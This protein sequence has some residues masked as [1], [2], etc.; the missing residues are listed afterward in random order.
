MSIAS[1]ADHEPTPTSSPR[2]GGSTPRTL[3]ALGALA[4]SSALASCGVDEVELGHARESLTMSQCSYFADGGR[5]RICHLTGSPRRP[6]NSLRLGLAGCNDHS[7][8]AGDYIAV[9]DPTCNGQGC[10][11]EGAPW[12]DTVECCQGLS[13]LAGTCR[14]VCGD[15]MVG[16]TEQ[17][18]DGNSIDTDA[19]TSAC[20]P[21][22]C[23]DGL[24]GP[25]EQC[26][27][28]N[29]IDTDACTSACEPARC[30]DGLVGPGEQCDDGN[31]VDGDGCSATCVIVPVGDPCVTDGRWT[32]ASVYER[33]VAYSGLPVVDDQ[34]VVYLAG[35]QVPVNSGAPRSAPSR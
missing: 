16:G 22:R 31:S 7:S 9:G 4:V 13:P 28:G 8:H 34:G 26:D 29:S 27:D 25:G 14:V 11:P 20:E 2:R 10:L 30:G 23:G 6:Y 24:V 19:C 35:R 5:V 3:V 32:C 17:C 1:A 21:A 18:D 12:D 15:G 33:G